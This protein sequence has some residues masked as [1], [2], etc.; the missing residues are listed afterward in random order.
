MGIMDGRCIGV[1][2]TVGAGLLRLIVRDREAWRAGCT[3]GERTWNPN[4]RDTH[5]VTGISHPGRR[6]RDRSRRRFCQSM[7]R[8][9]A[10]RYLIIDTQKLVAG[11]RGPGVTA[12]DRTHQLGRGRRS[13]SIFPATP[14]S[15]HRNIRR[16]PCEIAIYEEAT[17]S[18]SRVTHSPSTQGTGV[19]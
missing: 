11:K 17:A 6:R 19:A 1:A 10:I 12:L 9:W 2:F 4:L 18:L 14:S 7:M 13:S 15:R 3:H 16:S 5:A 8:T